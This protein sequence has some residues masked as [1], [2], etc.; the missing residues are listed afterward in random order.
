MNVIANVIAR[1]PSNPVLDAELARRLAG[2]A[3]QGYAY[4]YPHKTAYAPL[5]P[6]RALSD[7]WAAEPKRALELYVHV[8]FCAMRCGFCNLFTTVN[9]GGDVVARTLSQL[10]VEAGAAT[11]ALG[12][13][14]FARI[15]LGG[16]TPTFLAAD[17][18][19]RLFDILAQTLGAHPAFVPTSVE[20][21]P[22]TVT[23]EKLALLKRRGV[24]RLSIGVQ[25]FID[26]EARALGRPQR[27]AVIESA[28]DLVAAAGFPTLN[29]DLIYGAP[30][31]TAVSW[32]ASVDAAL[33]W[34]PDEIFLYPLYVRPLTG[35]ARM[36]AAASEH[37][38]RLDLYRRGRERLLAAGFAQVNMRCFRRMGVRAADHARHH[39]LTDGTLGIGCGAR[40]MTSTLHYANEYAVGRVGVKEILMNYLSR[41]PESFGLAHFGTALSLEDR[42]R[43]HILETLLEAH[44]LSRGSY[45]Q[46]FGADAIEDVPQLALLAS[47]GFAAI[48]ESDIRLTD[49]GFERADVIGP[50]LYSAE[51]ATRMESYLW[52]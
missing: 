10:A 12:G 26:G 50:W 51:V 9:P 41:P 1:V 13:A 49:A 32:L 19:D 14:H 22:D 40:S 31:Q 48:D 36:R 33:T 6:P 34:R 44:G 23:A 4:S 28:L 24:G 2:S 47:A 16:G 17:Q 46:A 35:L 3:Y 30:G 45:R 18:L 27:R 39:T 8:P 37:D 43:R 11:T 7:V 25:S 15:A 20:A 52:R 42:K 5:T 29:I 21:S 38:N